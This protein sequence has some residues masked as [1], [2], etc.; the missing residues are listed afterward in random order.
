MRKAPGLWFHLAHVALLVGATM[1]DDWRVRWPT[2]LAR[3]RVPTE[4]FVSPYES[5][6]DVAARLQDPRTGSAEM[7]PLC[8][9]PLW[10]ANA[11][12]RYAILVVGVGAAGDGAAPRGASCVNPYVRFAAYQ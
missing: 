8:P 5:P 1:L 2:P 10:R 4:Q 12:V 9:M 11:N 3:H 7:A 6:G